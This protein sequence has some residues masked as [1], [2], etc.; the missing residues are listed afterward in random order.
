MT[1][2]NQIDDMRTTQEIPAITMAELVGAPRESCSDLECAI[3]EY[4]IDQMDDAAF[5]AICHGDSDGVPTHIDA[6]VTARVQTGAYDVS[7]IYGEVT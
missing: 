2:Q 7:I 1:T 3:R 6:E 5:V 4:I